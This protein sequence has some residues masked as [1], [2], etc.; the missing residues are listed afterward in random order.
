MN[1]YNFPFTCSS[2]Y[3]ALLF[4][5]NSC[6]VSMSAG[7]DSQERQR[8]HSGDNRAAPA[9]PTSW[10]GATGSSA[11]DTDEVPKPKRPLSG[12]NIFFHHERQK[13][14]DQT[15]TREE[16]KPRRSH[17]KIGFA[18]LGKNIHGPLGQFATAIV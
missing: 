6:P 13:I 9:A 16:G 2:S 10:A 5:S 14:L 17:G 7:N 1:H 18:D 15:P 8:L 12:Y 3:D 11:K 4:P